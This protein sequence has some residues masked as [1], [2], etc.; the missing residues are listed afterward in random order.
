MYLT[1]AETPTGVIAKRALHG[2][3][4]YGNSDDTIIIPYEV[5][6]SML[7]NPLKLNSSSSTKQEHATPCKS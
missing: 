3:C 6:T 1:Q 7:S 4:K 5:V 2:P